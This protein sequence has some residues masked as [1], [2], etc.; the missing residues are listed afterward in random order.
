METRKLTVK[1]GEYQCDIDITVEEWKT[2]LQDKTIINDNCLDVLLK[3]YAEPEHK[4]TCKALEEK[5]HS[6]AQSFNGTIIAFAKATQKK[7]NRFQVVRDNG[8]PCYWIIAMLGKDLPNGLFEWTLR[9]ELVIAMEELKLLEAKFIEFKN[10]SDLINLI[11]SKLGN[12]FINKFRYKR[13]E[14]ANLGKAPMGGILFK[15]N[16]DGKN[17]A[18]NEGGGTEVQYHISYDANQS[19]MYFGIGFNT[20]YVPFKNKKTPV[21]YVQPFANAYLQ[22]SNS[23][24][25]KRVKDKG[26]KYD[27]NEQELKELKEGRYY[28]IGKE[29]NIVDNSIALQDFNSM[30]GE[31]KTDLF[32]LYCAIFEKRNQLLNKT[33]INMK[34]INLL[35][36]NK[37]LIFTGVPATGKTYLAKQITQ[38][39]DAEVAFVQFHPSYDYTDF[40][41]GLRPVKKDGDE[42]GFEL[43]DG[44]FKAFCK[45]AI[46]NRKV[47]NFDKY[48]NNFIDELS[49]NPIEL[50]TPSQKK[51]FK[52]E[53]NSNRTC[54]AIPTTAVATRMSITKEMI[55]NYIFNDSITEW[56]P[57]TIPI[58]NYFKDKYQIKVENTT[59]KDFVFII[60]EINR[61]EISKVFGELFYS[62]EADYRGEKGIVQTQYANLQDES[63]VF[64]KGFYV[65]ENVYIIG[66]MNDIDRSVE[67]MDFAMRR[68]FAWQ[69]ITAEDSLA[70]LDNLQI[71]NLDDIEIRTKAKNRLL[72][73]NQQISDIEE[74]GSAYHIGGAYFLKL[75]NYEGDFQQLWDYH[76]KGVLFEYLRGLPNADKHLS[77]LK[78]AYDNESNSDDKAE[79]KDAENDG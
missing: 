16:E 50:E 57:Y 40:V 58:A 67:S 15:N 38:E 4:A 14:L 63:D 43:K 10:F 36:A 18:I 56:K 54:V 31:I 79:I 24:L 5:Y 48:F 12:D 33:N 11:N 74:L 37:N 60:D 52:V 71:D 65:P 73:L 49:E 72:N 3:F 28:F 66:T 68:R 77:E 69:E 23:E 1:N 39:M 2:V 46:E 44:V 53:I 21:E 45:K 25:I 8:K 22:L 76:L 17:W 26:F 34:Y 47:D 27:G 7:L 35:K 64:A 62:I 32:E 70:I 9:P 41:E 29:I 75:K 42:L 6:S 51:K 19:N 30:I 20:E 55:K 78:Q 61:A 59:P 13:K